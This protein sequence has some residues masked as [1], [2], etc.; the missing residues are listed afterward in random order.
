MAT[1][2]I[3]AAIV[4]ATMTMTACAA[5]SQP[6]LDALVVQCQAG[7]QNACHAVPMAE[8]AVI[9]EKNEQNEKVA[10][11]VLLILS[12]G[13]LAAAVA[14]GARANPPPPPQPVFVPPPP[15]FHPPP[16]PVI[17]LH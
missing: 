10:K 7:D 13:L 9:R 1:R 2:T 11:G 14:A 5:P 15:P 12:V 8:A 6:V 16:P 4:A 17:F 3:T